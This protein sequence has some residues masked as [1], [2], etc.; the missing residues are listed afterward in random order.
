MASDIVVIDYGLGNFMSVV[1]MLSKI[2]ADVSIACDKDAILQA[3]KLILPGVGSYDKGIARLDEK[4]LREALLKKVMDDKTPI[5]GICLG[6][7]LFSKSSEEGLLEGLGFI[8]KKV[9]RFKQNESLY[10]LKV[11]HMGWNT[12]EEKSEHFLFKD[13]PKPMRFYFAH[14]YHY[15]MGNDDVAICTT[16]YGYDFPSM[17]AMNNLY[18][19]QFHPEKSHVYGMTLLRN[20]V[21]FA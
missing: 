5:L 1:K 8:D 14:S 9:V 7:Q 10:D 18:G 11:P 21:E 17:I 20:Y 12:V 6:M 19:V 13:M 2:G 16:N 15:P 4:G 3:K